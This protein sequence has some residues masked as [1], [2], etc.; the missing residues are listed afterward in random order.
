MRGTFFSIGHLQRATLGWWLFLFGCGC[1]ASAQQSTTAPVD[2]SPL[3]AEFV[4]KYQIPGAVVV[5]LKGDQ[6]VAQG[7]A[8][9][10]RKGHP[11]PIV[12]DDPFLIASCAKAMTA[13]LAATL[14]DDGLLRWDSTLEE[15]LGAA[16]KKIDPA[17]RKVTLRQLLN[18]QAGL[19]RER[20]GLFIRKTIFSRKSVR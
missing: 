8:G 4:A 18:H 9:V 15:M 2:V 19:T 12:I 14:I 1:V 3:L 11:D 16:V 17:W 5:V 7:A 6:I 10:R 20:Y 13:T